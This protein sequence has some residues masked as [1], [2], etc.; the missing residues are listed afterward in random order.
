MVADSSTI[1]WRCAGPGVSTRSPALLHS[2]GVNCNEDVF[3]LDDG[4]AEQSR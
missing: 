2:R 1:G 3:Q 4:Y